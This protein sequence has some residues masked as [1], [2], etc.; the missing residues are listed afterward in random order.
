MTVSYGEKCRLT[1]KVTLLLALRW[2]KNEIKDTRVIGVQTVYF[3]S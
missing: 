3:Y 1:V 2:I